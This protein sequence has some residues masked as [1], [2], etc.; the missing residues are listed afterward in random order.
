MSSSGLRLPTH[1]RT[2]TRLSEQ[3]IPKID[4]LY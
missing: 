2:P 1:L 4:A 3:F